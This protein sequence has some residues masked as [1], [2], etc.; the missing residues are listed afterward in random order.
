MR[1]GSQLIDHLDIEEVREEFASWITNYLD[2][3]SDQYGGMKP[4]PFAKDTWDSG[5]VRVQLGS[6]SSVFWEAHDWDD[7]VDL[8][9]VVFREGAA[10][11]LERECND[12]NQLLAD[13]GVDLVCIAFVP[14]DDEDEDPAIDPDTWGATIDE[15]YGFVFIQELSRLN[16]ASER[17]EVQG[18]YKSMSSAFMEYVHTRRKLETSHAR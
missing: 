17:L 3:P 12:Y 13:R 2:Q 8:S 11:Y 16:R 9:V 15:A 7:S 5:R 18:F 14:S 10:K 6:L 4:C 1:G